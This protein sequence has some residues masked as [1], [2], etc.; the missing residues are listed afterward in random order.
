MASNRRE[1]KGRTYTSLDTVITDY[2]HAW[3]N[4]GRR[5]HRA[6]KE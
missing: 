5:A 2:A 1:E 4:K 6:M 3:V